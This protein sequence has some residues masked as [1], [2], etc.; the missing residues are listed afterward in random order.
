MD[1]IISLIAMGA[2]FFAVLTRMVESDRE[3][4]RR[5][6]I[7]NRTNTKPWSRSKR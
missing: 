4:R 1:I 7:L 5:I 3:E 6:R 2:L